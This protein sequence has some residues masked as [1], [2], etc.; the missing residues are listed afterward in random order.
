[1]V[2]FVLAF[3]ITGF[4]LSVVIVQIIYKYVYNERHIKNAIFK[5][6]NTNRINEINELCTDE[7]LINHLILSNGEQTQYVIDKQSYKI[8]GLLLWVHLCG[9]IVCARAA[10]NQSFEQQHAGYPWWRHQMETI[11]ALLAICAGNSPA[12]GEFPAQRPVTRSF[13]IF[14]DLRLN[15]RLSK[16]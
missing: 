7:Y 3:K 16:Q 15:K 11:S 8:I 13:D 12:S 9:Y 14:F 5:V 1:M 2:L 10:A 6:S 4:M